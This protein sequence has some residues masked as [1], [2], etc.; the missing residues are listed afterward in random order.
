MKNEADF[1]VLGLGIVAVDDLLY[2]DTYPPPDAKTPIR[3][4][5]RQCGGLAATALVA[6]ARLGSRCAYAGLLGNDELSQF[7]EERLRHEGI[8][9]T[10]AVRRDEACPAHS[11]IVV[12]TSRQTRNIFFELAG[13]VGA[14]PDLPTEDAI[15]STKVLYVDHYG[16]EGI[17]RAARIA[18]AA[19][20]PVVADIERDESPLFIELLGV[21]DHLIVSHDFAAKITYES[22]PPAAAKA[23]WADGREAV[24]VTCGEEGCWY[25][26]LDT[27]DSPVHQPAFRVNTVDTTGCGDV[28]HGA[29][30]SALA[31]GLTLSERVRLASATAAMK[32][33]KPGGQSG[34][35][36]LP[37]VE[38]FL[39]ER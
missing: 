30:A 39:E 17:L 36:T 12:D 5:E 37:Q 15:R 34:I 23:L 24:V 16:M 4:R 10:H 20:I 35:P 7:V 38:A 25:L 11:F 29:Y 31:R 6:A 1:D 32:A 13:A 9:L 3:R 2:V 19:G 26:D 27:R 28:F 14:A 22:E 8:G 18:R 33:T 21:C